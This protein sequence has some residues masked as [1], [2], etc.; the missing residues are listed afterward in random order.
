VKQYP[1]PKNVKDV[2]GYLGLASFYRRLVPN[3]AEVAKPL[4]ELTRKNQEFAWGPNQQEA[5]QDMKH[6]LCSA[7][8]LAYPNFK[9]PFIL[10][11]DASRTALGA[12]LAQ[13]QDGVEK[14]V[15]YASRQ[16]N[17]A[18]RSYA[19]SELEMLALVWATKHFRCYLYG[20]KFLVR[21]DHAA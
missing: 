7:P 19:A 18:E 20:R 5:F 2:R 9:L 17:R 12:I 1:V 13:V 15:A 10:A 3:F 21:T 14:P 16:T 8:V 4:T 11:T 6:R